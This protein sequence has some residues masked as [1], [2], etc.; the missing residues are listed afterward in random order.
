[1]YST[2]MKGYFGG[3]GFLFLGISSLLGKFDLFIV[4]KDIFNIK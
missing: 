4:I 2:D 3:V 1:M